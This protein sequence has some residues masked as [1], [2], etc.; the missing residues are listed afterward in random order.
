VITSSLS[1]LSGF[2]SKNDPQPLETIRPEDGL[3]RRI[4]LYNPS[5]F[6]P[7]N[8]ISSLAFKPRK[9]DL[10][11]LSVDLERLTTHQRAILDKRKFRLA[12]LEARVPFS[13][14]LNCIHS[15][16]ED[17]QAHSLIQGNFTN[18]VSRQLATSARL[19]IV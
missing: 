8:S 19:L 5:Y 4:P 13:L 12:R 17:N 3:L 9:V 16:T 2:S 18:Q 1:L 15:P 6:K 10:G 7:D 11:G 14:G